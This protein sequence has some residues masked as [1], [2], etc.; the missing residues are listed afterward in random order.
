MD[1][2][3]ILHADNDQG[4]STTAVRIAGS[5]LANPFACVSAGVAS[6]WGPMHGGANE[7]QLDLFNDIGSVE[8]IPK[9]LE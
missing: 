3:F 7:D 5:S 6:L 4:P 1:K 9:Y 8:N 2:I